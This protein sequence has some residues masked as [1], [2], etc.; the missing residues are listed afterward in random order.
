V[1]VLSGKRLL[2]YILN[3]FQ[4]MTKSFFPIHL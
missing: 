2:I 4:F 1:N 3:S